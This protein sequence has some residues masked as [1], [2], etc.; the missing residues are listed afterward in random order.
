M[1]WLNYFALVHARLDLRAH[2]T[3][4]NR[5]QMRT[6]GRCQKLGQRTPP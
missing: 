6:V 2:A 4:E 3:V 5:E 1:L